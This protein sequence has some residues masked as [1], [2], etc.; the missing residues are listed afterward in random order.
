MIRKFKQAVVSTKDGIIAAAERKLGR[1]LTLRER[2]G[3]ESIHSLSLLQACHQAF[4]SALFTPAQVLA[5]LEYLVR[6]AAT[7]GS[8]LSFLGV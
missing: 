8:R 3:V 1:K 5:D 2:K 7:G 6:C 4:T